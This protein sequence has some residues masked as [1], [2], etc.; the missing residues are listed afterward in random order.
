MQGEEHPLPEQ[1]SLNLIPYSRSPMLVSC[2]IAAV[3]TID[4]AVVSLSASRGSVFPGVRYWLLQ[5]HF[6]LAFITSFLSSVIFIF[7]PRGVRHTKL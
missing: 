3:V 1:H 7:A 2:M 6:A 5:A 4:G